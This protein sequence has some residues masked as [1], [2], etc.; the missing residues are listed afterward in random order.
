[1][2]AAALAPAP[3]PPAWLARRDL[4]RAMS[5]LAG[6]GVDD[7]AAP[8]SAPSRV[9]VSRLAESRPYA[10]PE[11]PR[12][13]MTPPCTAPGRG[14]EA[15]TF[16]GAY[17]FTGLVLGTGAGGDVRGAV[18]RRTGRAVAVKSFVKGDLSATGKANL[19]RELE[20]QMATSHP[21]IVRC[22]AVFETDA[23][24]NIVMEQLRGG[25]LFD[26]VAASKRL[27]EAEAAS[28]AVQVL[29]AVGHLHE[30]RIVHR[31]I[32]PE[33]FVYVQQ[34][35]EC[36]KLIDFGFAT[37]LEAGRKLWQRCGTLQ[38]TAPEVLS[39]VGYDERCD[40]WSVGAM[41]YAVLVGKTLY[42][43]TQ[44]EVFAKNSQGTIEWSRSFKKLSREARDFVL[45]LLTVDV[46]KRRT[47]KQAL[48][49]PWLREVPHAATLVKEK[50]AS[51]RGGCP[52]EAE[53]VEARAGEARPG[54]AERARS[55]SGSEPEPELPPWAAG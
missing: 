53:V 13:P 25:D 39:G 5:A 27:T 2:T 36:L 21:S 23:D 49:H 35:G 30:R 48:R 40:M 20:L 26:R 47:A 15:E 52:P 4:E 18:C 50:G 43:G 31:D 55:G 11:A 8:A 34:G 9:R 16:E 32:K 19:R 29:R 28:V 7:A 12:G 24:A 10:T 54:L 44:D 37:R 38:Y 3:W 6:G 46:D 22:E 41:L 14:I 42:G 51:P 33:N 45:G 17:E 1:M